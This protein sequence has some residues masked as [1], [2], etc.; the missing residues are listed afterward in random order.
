M[1]RGFVDQ[2]HAVEG[3]VAVDVAVMLSD[4]ETMD[5]DGVPETHRPGSSSRGPK[6]GVKGSVARRVRY[7]PGGAVGRLGVIAAGCDRCAPRS[8]SWEL[9]LATSWRLL[10]TRSCRSGRGSGRGANA[11]DWLT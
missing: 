5:R 1:V 9:G 7:R 6:V 8:T 11:A 2:E 3:A 4:P 10:R